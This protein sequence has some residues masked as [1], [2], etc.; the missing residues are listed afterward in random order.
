MLLYNLSFMFIFPPPY[1]SCLLKHL[2]ICF[3]AITEKGGGAKAQRAWTHEGT[4]RQP[5]P[6]RHTHSVYVHTDKNMAVLLGGYMFP[7]VGVSIFIAVLIYVT[8]KML[9]SYL[10]KWFEMKPIPEVEGTYLFVG[11]ALQFKTN[12]GGEKAINMLPATLICM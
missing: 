1:I 5:A 9:G 4:G 6:F 7:L 12:A 3:R 11:S 8:Y 10:H 2:L